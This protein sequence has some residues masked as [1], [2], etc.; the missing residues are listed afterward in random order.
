MKILCLKNTNMNTS[1]NTRHTKSMPNMNIS[2]N[3]TRIMFGCIPPWPW[4]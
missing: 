1:M 4:A 2:R 3:I